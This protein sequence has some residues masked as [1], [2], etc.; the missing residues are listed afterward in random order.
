METLFTFFSEYTDSQNLSNFLAFIAIS[1]RI[2][3]EI[4]LAADSRQSPQ[5]PPV[6]LPPSVAQ[7]LA[8]GCDISISEVHTGWECLKEMIWNQEILDNNAL[9]GV[10]A[11]HGELNGF[12]E[13]LDHIL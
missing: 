13:G 6:C 5:D 2:K 11:K 9:K 1:M 10:F 3:K 7:F 8:L 4:L 12:C